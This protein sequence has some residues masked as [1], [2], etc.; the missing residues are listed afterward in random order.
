LRSALAIRGWARPSEPRVRFGQPVLPG[1]ATVGP[2]DASL[3]GE[4]VTGALAVREGRFA[5][6]G[7]EVGMRGAIDWFPRGASEA[8]LTAHHRLEPALA[9]G[10]AALVASGPTERRGWYDVGVRYAGSWIERVRGGSGP[11]WGL[12]ALG[13]RIV[14]LLHFHQLFAGELRDDGDFRRRLLTSVYGQTEYLATSVARATNDPWLVSAGRALVLAGR[15]FDG[16]EARAWVEQGTALVWEQLREQVNEDG[17]DARRSPVWQRA[18]LGEYLEL[19]AVLK[20]SNDD[21][22]AWVRKRVRGMADFLAR[23]SHPNGQAALFGDAPVMGTRSRE[24]L[25]ALAAVVLGEPQ[26]ALAADLR[27]IW[28]RLML[29]PSGLRVQQAEDGPPP[30][31]AESRA[32]RRTGFYVLAGTPGDVMI[33]DGGT[34]PGRRGH[35]AFELSVGGVPII[36]GAG[37]AEREPWHAAYFGSPFAQNVLAEKAGG[38]AGA[39]GATLEGTTHWMM[40]DGLVSF[41]ATWGERRRLVLCLPGRFWLVI[42]QVNGTGPWAGESLLH[43]D[44]SCR[45]EA[46]CSGRPVLLVSRPPGARCALAFAGATDVRLVGGLVAPRVQGWMARTPGRVEPAQTIV[47]PVAGT[48]PLVAGYA[49]V[50]RGTPDVMLSLDGETLEVHATL[51]IARTEYHL[52]VLQDEIE[53]R[54]GVA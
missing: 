7:H 53:L 1:I 49:M 20:A 43:L 3:A 46:A 17:G 52:R 32:L 40:R 36:V 38:T 42:D 14:N 33:L 6:A 12:E 29:G 34:T 13:H 48:R 11:A 47:L 27:A 50:P 2:D 22:P 54:S 31:L 25:L 8:W 18:V 37:H 5:Y 4:F 24:E 35:G 16:L 23:V 19:L 26:W 44:P 28:P 10:V 41:L 39:M 51:R 45:V 15:F 9:V 30:D 21:I